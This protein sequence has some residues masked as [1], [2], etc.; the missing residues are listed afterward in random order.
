MLQVNTYV[1]PD[2]GGG[3]LIIDPSDNCGKVVSYLKENNLR[4]LAILLTHGHFDHI[5]GIPEIL[6][7]YGDAKVYIHDSDRQMLGDPMANRSAR[8]GMDFVYAQN[9]VPL[10]EGRMSV[11]GLEFDVLHTPGH[12]QGG[13]DFVFDGVCFCGDT[14]FANSVGRSDFPGGDHEQLISSIREKI[15]TLPPEMTLCPGHGG[16]T[17]VEREMRSNPY[18]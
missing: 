7:E 12:T 18:L 9:I 1:I 16:R 2:G 3:C 11:G 10:T 8:R 14:I 6:G 13:C 17:T 5:M 15:M 4:P